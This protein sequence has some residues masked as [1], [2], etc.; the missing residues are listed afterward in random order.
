MMIKNKLKSKK[1]I[2][3]HKIIDTKYQ[4]LQKVIDKIMNNL[5]EKTY[6]Q[7]EKT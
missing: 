3:A 4:D 6:K 5:L 2:N 7:F 1:F